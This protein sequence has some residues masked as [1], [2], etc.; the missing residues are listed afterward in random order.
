M[1]LEWLHLESEMKPM[2]S[3]VALKATSEKLLRPLP[4]P[5]HAWPL[6][7]LDQRSLSLVHHHRQKG[8]SASRSTTSTTAKIST[9]MVAGSSR[10]KLLKTASTESLRRSRAM[11]ILQNSLVLMTTKIHS[12]NGSDK[13]S[14]RQVYHQF[15]NHKATRRWYARFAKASTRSRPS[16]SVLDLM[17]TAHPLHSVPIRASAQEE[18]SFA[19]LKG[20]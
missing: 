3:L 20:T 16:C 10:S 17:H 15:L 2:E 14:Q 13:S 12:I 4:P 6:R 8:L 5:L 7:P 11:K 18:F 9:L 1:A 19:T